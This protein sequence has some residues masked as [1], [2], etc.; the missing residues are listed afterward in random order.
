MQLFPKGSH[1]C[2]AYFL[3]APNRSLTVKCEEICSG[4]ENCP[5]RDNTC[6]DLI[7]QPGD[8]SLLLKEGSTKSKT[9]EYL[10]P[11][12]INRIKA[13]NPKIT[14]VN[15]T[16]KCP[17]NYY[18][19]TMVVDHKNTFHF[20]RLN[21]NGVWS[22]KPGITSVKTEDATG[23]PIVVPHFADRNYKRTGSSDINY[24]DFCGYFCIPRGSEGSKYFA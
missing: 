14:Q 21:S 22:H 12:M 11:D 15:F 17:A 13:D 23:K 5:G 1:N 2:Y 18:K 3:D 7:P 9:R 8:A 10:C 6:R 16:D 19:G 20:Y 4:K 24:N